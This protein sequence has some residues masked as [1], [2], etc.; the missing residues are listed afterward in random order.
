MTKN[1]TVAVRLV[2]GHRLKVVRCPHC[3]RRDHHLH[4]DGGDAG[5]DY[6]H[7]VSHCIPDDLPPSLRGKPL[8]YFLRLDHHDATDIAQEHRK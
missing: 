3:G 5:P 6:G 1:P 7:R 2:D 4:G 8:G